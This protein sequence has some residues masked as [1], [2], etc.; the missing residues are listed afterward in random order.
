VQPGDADQTRPGAVPRLSEPAPLSLLPQPPQPSLFHSLLPL[1][2]IK[3]AQDDVIKDF[4]C[5]L[6]SMSC[7]LLN[8]TRRRAAAQVRV[9][10]G[11][12]R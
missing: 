3:K 1:D 11:D 10:R 7:L 12:W 6:A 2:D 9:V 5:V 4:T 8:P